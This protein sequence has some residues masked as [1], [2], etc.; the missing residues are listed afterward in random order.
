GASGVIAVVFTG[1]HIARVMPDIA[2]P[3]ARLERDAMWNVITFL[4]E[5]LVFI[6]VGLELPAV[7]HALQTYPRGMM[8]REAGLLRLCIVLVRLIWV[9]PSAYVGRWIGKKLF[10]TTDP[11]ARFGWIM[12]VGWVGLRGG[13]SVVVALALPETTAAGLPF[14]AREQI[15]FIVFVVTL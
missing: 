3:E 14:P 4:L 8:I 7:T 10:G 12:F 5:S 15:L 11:V 13:D 6:L 2:G 1:M 9:V